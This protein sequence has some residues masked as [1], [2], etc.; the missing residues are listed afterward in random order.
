MLRRLI[1]RLTRHH[2][3]GAGQAL[4]DDVTLDLLDDD[5]LAGLLED[6]AGLGDLPVP[7]AARERSWALVREEVRERENRG[8]FATGGHRR[9]AYLRYALGSVAVAIAAVVGVVAF[10]GHEPP[11]VVSNSTS[12]SVTQ[13]PTSTAPGTTSTEPES[14][15]STSGSPTTS[16]GSTPG[17]GASTTGSTKAP[18]TTGTTLDSQVTPPTQSPTTAR[19]NEST[20]TT[21]PTETTEP[22]RSTTTGEPVMTQAQRESSAYTVAT[23]LGQEVAAGNPGG[24]SRVLT[25]SAKPLFTI[26]VKS[27]S[28]PTAPV[29]K[30]VSGGDPVTRVVLAFTDH[31]P[32]GQG[33]TNAVERRFVLDVQIIGGEALITGIFQ[34][35]E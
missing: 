32:D 30:S 5:D 9:P 21:R 27:M 2:R 1:D 28:A 16:G 14:P 18:S 20:D 7:A 8:A 10:T 26:M 13:A 35:A 12:T 33:G 15:T 25:S 17:A 34:A 23:V 22:P 4:D 6:L 29:I 19:T 3:A 31:V 24:A 11:K